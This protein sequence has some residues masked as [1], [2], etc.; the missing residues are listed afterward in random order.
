AGLDARRDRASDM[1]LGAPVGHFHDVSCVAEPADVPHRVIIV[2]RGVEANEE[3]FAPFEL[4][5]LETDG[6]IAPRR[7]AD[8]EES[9]F[10]LGGLADRSVLDLPL[11]AKF[12]PVGQARF[13]GKIASQQ[14]LLSASNFN[15]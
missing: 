5:R 2:A 10:L 9:A 15:V 11:A 13:A 8:Q 6:V 7:I 1:R 12:L 14:R 4:A 3:S